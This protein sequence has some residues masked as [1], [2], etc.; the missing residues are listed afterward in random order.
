[1]RKRIA[2][3]SLFG[4]A[5]LALLTIATSV[6]SADSPTVA[7]SASASP[8]AVVSGDTVTYTLTVENTAENEVD[9]ATL[10]VTLPDGFTYVSGSTTLTSNGVTKAGV[11]PVVSG[12]TLRWS[13][14]DFTIPAAR[15]TT[16]YGMNTF[17]QDYCNTDGINQQLNWT[18]EVVGENTYAK[19]LFKDIEASTPGPQPCWEKFVEICYANNIT[20]V[21]RLAGTYGSGYWNKPIADAPGDYSSIAAAFARVVDGLRQYI[22]NDHLLYIEIWNEPNLN[23]EWGDEAN[24]EEYAAMMVDVS[25]AIRALGDDR[26]VIMNGGLSPNGGNIAALAFIDR[27]ARVSG[28]LDSFDVWAA[29]TYPG[30]RPPEYNL[31]AGNI[32]SYSNYSIDSYLLE[33]QRLAQYGRDDLQVLIT[34]TGYALSANDLEYDKIGESNRANYMLRAMTD[35]WSQWSEV[36]GVCPFELVDPNG[37]W[38]MWDWRDND[39]STHAQYDVLAAASKP[40]TLVEGTLELT[41]EARSGGATGT[42]TIDATLTTPSNGSAALT[43]AAPVRIP[44]DTVLPTPTPYSAGTLVWNLPLIYQYADLTTEPTPA[45][46]QGCVELV[47]NGNCETS[48]VWTLQGGYP[49]SYTSDAYAGTQALRIGIVNS[50]K[51]C[52]S[53]SSVQQKIT[54]PEADDIALIFWAK[55][56]SSDTSGDYQCILLRSE[57]LGT[58][59]ALLWSLNNTSDWVGYYYDLTDY[60]GQ[61]LYLYFGVYND[62]IPSEGVTSMLVDNISVEACDAISTN[63]S[64]HV[65]IQTA[66]GET[67][68]LTTLSPPVTYDLVEGD[69][70]L[71]EENKADARVST[72]QIDEALQRMVVTRYKALTSV[73]LSTGEIVYSLNYTSSLGIVGLD[74]ATGSVAVPLFDEGRVDLLDSDGNLLGAVSDLG[75]PVAAILSGQGLLIA[76]AGSDQLVLA[77]AK[78]GAVV[79]SLDLGTIPDMMLLDE[80]N[81]KLYVAEPEASRLA[82]INTTNL[83]IESYIELTGT[84]MPADMVLDSERNRLYIVNSLSAKYGGIQAI[85]TLTGRITASLWGNPTEPLSIANHVQLSADGESVILLTPTTMYLLDPYTLEIISQ[86]ALVPEGYSRASDLDTTTGELY[87]ADGPIRVTRT[88]GL[89]GEVD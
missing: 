36:I 25:A 23:L 82:L 68:Q 6:A 29:H 60:A 11:N 15:T 54:L 88:E 16:V 69:I 19:Q 46:V 76:D 17:V 78:S 59:R 81:G 26:I 83:A 43:N 53:F 39:G 86:Q 49:A 37:N 32:T 85:D 18:L 87:V 44:S 67:V 57:D 56:S 31:H 13:A 3:R 40:S 9:G 8:S 84:A 5:L 21:I 30:N 1:M 12:D 10:V 61:T 73:D 28:W 65:A 33:L 42:R 75:K 89:S 47:T 20:P 66:T 2:A 50:S 63:S 48:S 14:S 51:D 22:P 77:D 58:S 71:A 79:D 74:E 52:Y 38:D 35:Y 41:F 62:G 70:S 24:P 34:E 7:M 64:D 55:Y 27:M 80:A 4:V 45:P 72:L